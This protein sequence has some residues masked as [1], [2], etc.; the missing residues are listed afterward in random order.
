MRQKQ[1]CCAAITKC[2]NCTISAM[3]QSA[4]S[5]WTL[6]WCT[7][8]SKTGRW[9]A[10]SGFKLFQCQGEAVSLDGFVRT[11]SLKPGNSVGCSQEKKRLG[12]CGSFAYLSE[13]SPN[14]APLTRV[15]TVILFSEACAL[16][17]SE[18]LCWI[19][20]SRQMEPALRRLQMQDFQGQSPVT[21][22]H[23]K[24][25]RESTAGRFVRIS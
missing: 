14:D 21:F 8:H 23:S 3:L 12:V 9:H 18:P 7:D 10:A 1:H 13:P 17:A 15:W 6:H 11:L 20:P 19:W 2:S 4:A 25:N 5:H 22:P 16:K 24:L